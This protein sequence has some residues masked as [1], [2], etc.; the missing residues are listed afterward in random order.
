MATTPVRRRTNR[1]SPERGNDSTPLTTEQT[2]TTSEI[3]RRAFELYC[4]RGY[5]PGHELDD[6]LQA[7]GELRAAVAAAPPRPR[8]RRSASTES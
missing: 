1:T 3:A 6:W 8:R 5:Q 7:E 2:L 4:A